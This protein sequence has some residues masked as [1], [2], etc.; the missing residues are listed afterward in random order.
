MFFSPF[1]IAITSLEE[2]RTNLG[3]AF[4]AFVR[5]ALVWFCLFPLPLGVWEGLRFVMLAL[6]EL[7]SYLFFLN[8][9]NNST[10][11]YPVDPGSSLYIMSTL[12]HQ[13]YT[14]S[15][16]SSTEIKHNTVP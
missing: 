9:N 2:E 13:K 12:V 3:A 16:G 11:Q 1:S 15:D 4:R 7:F 14:L 8:Y 5:F 6:P 10:L